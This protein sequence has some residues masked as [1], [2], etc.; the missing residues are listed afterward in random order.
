[1][2]GF[3]AKKTQQQDQQFLE[4]LQALRETG[5]WDEL[6]QICDKALERNPNS[7]PVTYERAT[8]LLEQKRLSEA[9]EWFGKAGQLGGPGTEDGFAMQV[10]CLRQAN[11]H[12]GAMQAVKDALK[13]PQ[14][15]RGLSCELRLLL[16][17]LYLLEGQ[18][19]PALELLQQLRG[20]LG[21]QTPAIHTLHRAEALMQIEGKFDEAD[22][23]VKTA[24]RLPDQEVVAATQWLQKLVALGARPRTKTLV[25]LAIALR[26]GKVDWESVEASHDP[27]VQHVATHLGPP[28]ASLPAGELKLLVVDPTPNCPHRR[29]VTHGMS[30][31][32]MKGGGPEQSWAELMVTVDPADQPEWTHQLLEELADLPHREGKMLVAGNVM[33]NPG[34]PCPYAGFLVLPSITAPKAFH[35]LRLAQKQVAFLAIYPLYKEEVELKSK[36]GVGALFPLFEQHGVSD[37]VVASRTNTALS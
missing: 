12:A 10:K 14:L 16:A 3:L 9:A 19:M 22:K 17:K 6:I 1:M 31:K 26:D 35:S 11:D 30:A 29:I 23:L 33:R 34:L 18:G 15:A 4:R 2:F 13:N 8:Y 25:E 21:T 36:S 32:P 7:G 20:E 27:I 28:V 37:K 5:A 24:L